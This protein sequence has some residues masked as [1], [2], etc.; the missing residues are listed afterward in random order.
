MTTEFMLKELGSQLKRA[1]SGQ[2]QDK[3]RI[4]SDDSHSGLE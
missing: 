4:E 3:V 2:R 1:A